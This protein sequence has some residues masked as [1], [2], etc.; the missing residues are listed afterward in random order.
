MD[1]SRVKEA[2][3]REILDG[4]AQYMNIQVQQYDLAR[5]GLDPE[6]IL[7]DVKVRIWKIIQSERTILCPGSY[8][9][10]IITSAVI[11]QLRKRRRE[12]N[13][14]VCEKLKCI[15]EQGFAYFREADR[16]K[17]LEETVGRAVEGLIDSRR[18]V[19]KLYLMNLSI[20]EISGYLKWTQDKTRNLLYRGL[21]DLR[22]SLKEMEAKNE[23]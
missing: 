6:D 18:Q 14:V 19:V 13:L 16:K 11:D 12:D 23:N 10:K 8:I 9:R 17:G 15:S 5:F 21:S 22:E 1:T 20:Q 4:Y 2:E 7:Q 3:F